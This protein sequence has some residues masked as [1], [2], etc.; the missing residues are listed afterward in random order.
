M[1]L[2]QT[3]WS[4]LTNLFGQ[5]PA[6]APPTTESEGECCDEECEP[7]ED[8]C[9]HEDCESESEPENSEEVEEAREV[10]E[11]PALPAIEQNDITAE[12]LITELFLSRGVTQAAIE[13]YEIP[14]EFSKWY[15]GELSAESVLESIPLFRA[16]V[17]ACWISKKVTRAFEE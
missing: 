9:D 14:N 3:L 11:Q 1:N 17:P 4:W 8:C 13:K 16:A 12:Q 6:I 5:A 2:L 7:E 10:E 15:N